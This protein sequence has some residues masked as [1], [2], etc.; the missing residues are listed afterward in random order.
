MIVDSGGTEKEFAA[1]LKMPAKTDIKVSGY[2]IGGAAE[3]A[4]SFRFWME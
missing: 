4:A 3:A 1:P 2:G